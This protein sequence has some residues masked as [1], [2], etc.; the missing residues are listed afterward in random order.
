MTSNYVARQ[1][2]RRSVVIWFVALGLLATNVVAAADSRD[3][4]IVMTT[5][6]DTIELT[7][8]VSALALRIPKGDL[9]AVEESRTGVQGSPKYFHLADAGRGLVVSGWIESA[10]TFRGFETFW[11]GEFS[12]MKRSG[13]IPTASPMPVAVG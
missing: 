12:A 8:P 6:R 5:T 13:L 2:H 11:V 1:D 9:A 7:V 10:K 3:S 4:T